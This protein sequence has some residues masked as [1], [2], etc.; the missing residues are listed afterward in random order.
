MSLSQINLKSNVLGIKEKLK[1]E[2]KIHAHEVI[3]GVTMIAI[4][5]AIAVAITGDFNDAFAKASRR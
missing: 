5:L 2:L 1:F 3:V 4:S